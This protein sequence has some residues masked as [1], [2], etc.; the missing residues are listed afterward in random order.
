MA[1]IPLTDPAPTKSGRWHPFG[2]G[3][4]PFFLLA[5]L[6]GVVLILLW[7]WLRHQG[8]H[9]AHSGS[10]GWHGHEMLFGY[11]T[12]V[13]AGFLL[14]AVRNWTGHQTLNGLPLALLALLWLTARILPWVSQVPSVLVAV[15]DL[16]FLPLL[17]LSLIRPLWS[18]ANPVNR[19]FLPLLLAMAAANALVH[20]QALGL[21]ADGAVRGTAAM[22]DLVILLLVMVGGRVIPFF[23][24]KA[25]TGA[26]PRRYRWVETGGI[27]LLVLLALT[28]AAGHFPVVEGTLFLGLGALQAVR[29][30]GWHHP[31]IWRRPI[32]WVLF[33]GYG[34]IIAG[35][36]LSGIAAL[37]AFPRTLAI[38]ALT[39]G[40][41][42]VM[43]LGMM[44]RVALGHT[45]RLLESAPA[46]NV[47]FVVINLAVV[48]RV[49][50]PWAFPRYYDHWVD[51]SGGLWILAF[52]LLAVVY[53]PIL[54]KPRVDGRAN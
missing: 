3:F 18:G 46:T 2:L 9:I 23:T 41:I 35:L 38:H 16:L 42:G 47:A 21:L 17:A 19:V 29:I 5:A 7:L 11:S 51:L 40:G 24:E 45:G 8:F 27:A 14:T 34:W 22:L 33:T 36:W 30:A 48:A 13:I 12:A 44:A 49:A 4:R 10:V 6:A 39:I 52:A 31:G 43:T 50:G 15:T 37:D 26:R 1:T 54:M 32:L 53:T 25:V 28:H 20:A